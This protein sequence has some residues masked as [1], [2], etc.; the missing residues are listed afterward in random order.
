MPT[1]SHLIYIP[2]AI[3]VGMILG[4][5]LGARAARDQYNLQLRKDKERAEARARREARKQPDA[6]ATDDQA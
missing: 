1:A 4:F 6:A 3:L 5:I 2:G